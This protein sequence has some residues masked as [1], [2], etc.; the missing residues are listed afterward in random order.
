MFSLCLS[1][2]YVSCFD[3]CYV[4]ARLFWL[5]SKVTRRCRRDNIFVPPSAA[6]KC[7][8]LFIKKTHLY[9]KYLLIWIT[10]G[11]NYWR[12]IL[13]LFVVLLRLCGVHKLWYISCAQCPKNWR[14][15]NMDVSI[16]IGSWVPVVLFCRLHILFIVF[17]PR[18]RWLLSIT[19]GV[20]IL[21]QYLCSNRP[22]LFI[23]VLLSLYC[24]SNAC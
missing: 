21:Q 15:N 7:N 18:S 1:A 13:T 4:F 14:W 10:I 9:L 5:F 11:V 12:H 22:N 3:F 24:W 23:C 20:L 6:V 8:I 19:A 2:V 17:S 16:H